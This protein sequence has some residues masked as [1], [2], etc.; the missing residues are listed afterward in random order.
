[1]FVWV[2]I[3]LAKSLAQADAE[4]VKNCLWMIIVA[5]VVMLGSWLYAQRV[6]LLPVTS[7]ARAAHSL[8]GGDLSTRAGLSSGAAELIGLGTDFDDMAA[9]LESRQAELLRIN[10]ALKAE[11]AE[12]QE[13]QRRM[14]EQANEKQK[15]EQQLLRSQRMESLGALAGGIAHDLN[16]ALA[17]IMMGADLLRER[18]NRDQEH[19]EVV[20]LITR[21]VARCTQMV[22][23]IVN[24]AKGTTSKKGSLQIAEVIAEMAKVARD[25]F[26]KS[27]SVQTQIAEGLLAVSGDS[28]E[29]HQVLMN[30]CVNARDAMPGGGELTLSAANASISPP[31]AKNHPGT[32]PGSCVL[33]RVSDTGC[34]MSPETVA[35]IFEP[36]FTTKTPDQGTGLGLSTVAQIVAKHRG[37]VEVESKVGAGT[38]FRIFLPATTVADKNGPR[39]PISALPSGRGQLIL[40]VD[41]EQLLLELAKTTLEEYGYRVITAHNGLEAVET[42]AGRK[43]DIDLIITDTDMPVL[44]GLEAIECIQKVRL[45]VPIIVASGMQ[46]GEEF[47]TGIDPRRVTSLN[48]PYGVER[49]LDAVT[50][51]LNS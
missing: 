51:V 32:Q 44:T 42:F 12:R 30:L 7:L 3:P 10:D 26:P 37:F 17:P 1:M 24:F 40:V 45:D 33:L 34:G 6:V 48:K 29:L 20:E 47:L 38:T 15:L 19:R 50:K 5:A 46:P 28:T 23:Q 36:F 21:S 35:R 14:L 9:K 13:A 31:Q 18:G 39:Q 43:A 41:D 2:S 16:N 11:I 22:K 4:L 49:L 8:A 27:I 25:T